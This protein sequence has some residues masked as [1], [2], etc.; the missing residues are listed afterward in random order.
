MKTTYL[1]LIVL[2]FCACSTVKNNKTLE[3]PEE[4]KN[5]PTLTVVKIETKKEGYTAHLVDAGKMT[6][7]MFVS[8]INLKDKFVT[9]KV[10]D[11]IKASGNYAESIPVIIYVNS[12]FKLN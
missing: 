3:I 12:V 2:V 9:L 7:K 4:L 8:E 11:S 5:F 10:G 6:Y 1:A